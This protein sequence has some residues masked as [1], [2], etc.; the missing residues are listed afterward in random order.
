MS[1]TPTIILDRKWAANT[2]WP[3]EPRREDPVRK[4][5]GELVKLQLGHH[6]ILRPYPASICKCDTCNKANELRKALEV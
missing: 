6:A 3:K 4:L 1:K 5:A 2:K